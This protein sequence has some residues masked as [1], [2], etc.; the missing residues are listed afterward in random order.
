[1]AKRPFKVYIRPGRRGIGEAVW[2]ETVERKKGRW[3]ARLLNTAVAHPY[4]WG[5]IVKLGKRV[6]PQARELGRLP[7]VVGKARLLKKATKKKATKK[8]KTKKGGL[9]SL[10]LDHYLRV[11]KLLKK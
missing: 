2:A 4:E 1:M 9:E 5:D 11:R 8:T 6:W 3:I 10:P 7:E